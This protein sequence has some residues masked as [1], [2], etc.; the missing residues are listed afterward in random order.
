MKTILAAC[1]II[2]LTL[3][4]AWACSCV[5]ERISE[6]QQVAKAYAQA[7]LIF[8]GRVTSV[9]KVTRVDTVHARSRHSGRDTVYNI[10]HSDV[11]YTFAVS[12]VWKGKPIG[13]TV[14]LV[15]AGP[16]SSCGVSYAVGSER[17]VY[18]H[19]VDEEDNHRGSTRKIPPYYSTGLCTRTKELRYT[20]RREIRQ[21][22]HLAKKAQSEAS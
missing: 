20:Q 21:L 10:P 12:R 8:T 15:T 22:G 16:S 9:E 11:R 1:I 3:P 19:S 4:S 5:G 18:A 7:S 17:L 13:P 6:K 2:L 14:V